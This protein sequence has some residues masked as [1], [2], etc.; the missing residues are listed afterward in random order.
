MSH[1]P[2]VDGDQTPPFGGV[3]MFV[4]SIITLLLSTP[5]HAATTSLA[6][7]GEPRYAADF[8]NLDYVNPAA[9]KGGDMKTAVSGSF[10]NLNGLV[11]LGNHGEG[12]ELLDDKLMQRAWN[13]PF[14]LYG[15]VAQSVDVA[16]DRS[17]IT[18]HLNPK[19]RFH[20]GVRMT[21]EDVKWSYEMYRAHGHPVRRRVYGLV[22]KVEILS[23][24]DIKFTFDK[25]YD[26]E[27][28][29]ILALMQILPKHYW[30]QYDIT[31]TTL[32]P[33]LGSG[34]Y[35]IRDVEPG[36]KIVYERV[37]D[38]WAKDLPINQGMYNFDTVTYTYYR[39]DDISLQAFK[40]GDYNLRHEYNVHK[41]LTSYDCKALR[42]GKIIQEEIPHQRPEWLRAMIFNT[43]RPQ[44]Q[45]R[46]VREALGLM[47]NFDWLNKNLFLG[48]EKRITSIFPNSE[49]AA[50]G[51]P[52]GA[53][54]AELKKYK[55][56]LPS[57]VFA[58]AWQP[59][60]NNIRDN[61]RQAIAL[62]KD[63]G[64]IYKDETLINAK[65]G[66]PFTFEILL[67]DP[68]DEK[69][70]LAFSRDLK[71]IGITARVRTV[72]SAQ[73]TGRLDDF[74]YDMVM[75]R[76]INSLSPGN[77]QVN[78]WG[79]AAAET[80][81]TRNY[82]GVENPAIDALAAS[83]A[84]T[85]D[86]ATLVA[87]AKALDRAIMWSY[88]FIPMNYLGADMIAHSKNIHRPAAVP[89]YGI[90]QESLW[91]DENGK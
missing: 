78:Y 45:D 83:I 7:N 53:E 58:A 75:H 17:W 46:R 11:I 24:H 37:K 43:R 63:A 77:E 3:V 18:F 42:E 89:I 39:D 84:Q 91:M 29:M 50:T 32:E 73:F 15:L 52:E 28:V 51:K 57:E 54:L 13:E 23:P 62:L 27:T 9:P 81:G 4:V 74:D 25:G 14:T 48:A 64:W 41:W 65:T 1:M 67:N 85:P 26:R 31:K 60:S 8:K 38:Y 88:Y 59:P 44:F 76:W 86:R 40:A 71:R 70:A 82:A 10:D 19:A 68:S 30:L 55:A 16:P 21:A 36:R 61:E 12:L 5:A 80:K 47:F 2:P 87:R 35:R 20:D 90:V 56:Q 34:P 22:S 6:M 79:T 49:L 69:I 66:E 33:P 72:D